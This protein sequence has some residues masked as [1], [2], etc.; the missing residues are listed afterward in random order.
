MPVL[1][2]AVQVLPQSMPAG[3]LVTVPLPLSDGGDGQRLSRRLPIGCRV[4]VVCETPSAVDFVPESYMKRT[5][6]ARQARDSRAEGRPE[7][8]AVAEIFGADTAA[9]IEP[10]FCDDRILGAQVN[11]CSASASVLAG[12]G[13]TIAGG[14]RP[15]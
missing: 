10:P 14:G 12:T 7:G 2:D 1:Y 15:T 9:H 6:I 3:L 11:D 4:R 5:A 13:V 8:A